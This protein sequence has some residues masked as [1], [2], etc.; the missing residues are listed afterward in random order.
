MT[1]EKVT[2]ARQLYDSRHYTVEAIAHSLGVSKASIYRSL[3]RPPGGAT[4]T[5]RS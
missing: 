4:V 3:G 5:G 2:M 1:P